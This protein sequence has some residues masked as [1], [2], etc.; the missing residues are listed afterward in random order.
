LVLA[1][2]RAIYGI[3]FI[4]TVRNFVL[5]NGLVACGGN[6]GSRTISDWW[7]ISALHRFASLVVIL[8]HDLEACRTYAI[9]TVD[10]IFTLADTT[11]FSATIVDVSTDQFVRLIVLPLLKATVTLARVILEM[12]HARTMGS[13]RMADTVIDICT[14]P[15]VW[16]SGEVGI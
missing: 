13:A 12:V 16:N 5:V 11:C 4:A 2:E 15:K 1:R 10:K 3:T 7:G 6:G 9:E 8:A 14:I